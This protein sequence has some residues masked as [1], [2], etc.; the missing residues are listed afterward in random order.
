[1]TGIKKLKATL[2]AGISGAFL[3]ASIATVQTIWDGDPNVVHLNGRITK[4]SAARFIQE[5][6]VKA[7]MHRGK[8]PLTVSIDSVGGD[9]P[10]GYRIRTAIE[11]SGTP[12]RLRCDGFAASM[13]AQ[14]FI[15]TEHAKRDMSRK[16]LLMVHNPSGAIRGKDGDYKPYS[17]DL[18]RIAVK[19]QKANGAQDAT[20][21]PSR[22]KLKIKGPDGEAVSPE[23][24]KNS[25][26]LL[27][28]LLGLRTRMILEIAAA[29]PRIDMADLQAMFT[30]KGFVMN[31]YDAYSFG[32]TDT[33]EGRRPSPTD[34]DFNR[35]L[36]CLDTTI[37]LKAC[38][39]HDLPMPGLLMPR[40]PH[41]KP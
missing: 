7:A 27:G 33:V 20:S 14:I 18:L 40:L 22:Q 21:T 3:A 28:D 9:V 26:Y 25:R 6:N 12:V 2:N 11:N 16:C 31:A 10:S 32:M 15:T 8:T 35:Y 23:I 34:L 24:L 5:F 17:I 41:A 36:M 29:A 38:R 39:N 37:D 19:S 30:T 4:F 13:A 1:M